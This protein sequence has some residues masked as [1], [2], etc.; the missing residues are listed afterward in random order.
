LEKLLNII[1]GCAVQDRKAQQVLYD[2]FYGVCLKTVFRYVDTYEQAVEVANDGFVKIFRSFGHFEIRDKERIEIVLLGWMRRIM[3][4]CAIDFRRRQNHVIETSQMQANVW[5]H[6]DNSQ[7]SDGNLKY[8]ELISMI[9]D[10]PPAYR[11]VFNLHV[12]EGYSHTEIAKM[13]GITVGTS[14]SNLF[15]ARAQLQKKLAVNKSEYVL[16]QI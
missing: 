5:E 4:N 10:L 6:E 8:K 9:R 3:I 15:K 16:C 13:I 14:K 2:R 7:L 1:A 11:L 12:I